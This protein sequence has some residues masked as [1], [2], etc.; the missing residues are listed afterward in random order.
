MHPVCGHENML[1]GMALD[2]DWIKDMVLTYVEFTLTHQKA[3][4]EE[5]GTPDAIWFYEDLGFKEKPF[6]SP[7]MFEDI[8][9]PGYKKAFDYAHSLGCKV[10][11]HSCGYVAPL[12]PGLVRAGMDCL[13]AME[14]KA[15]MD[16][17]EI[18]KEFGDRIS[19]CGNFD[20]REI[21]S[22]DQNRID[23]EFNRRVKPVLDM[24]CGYILHSDHSIPPQVDHDTLHYFFD[25]CSRMV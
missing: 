15:G 9:V 22:N 5:Q 17:I 18:A 11:V 25:H 10:V 23:S 13:Q 19:F 14:V 4:F 20:I 24:G 8:M 3:L 7:A 16:M 21:I 12:V 6:M 2:P 1:M